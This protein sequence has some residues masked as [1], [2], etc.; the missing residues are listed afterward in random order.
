MVRGKSNEQ[1]QPVPTYS[2]TEHDDMTE[3]T[4]PAKDDNTK[5]LRKQVKDAAEAIIRYKA[6][7]QQ[8]NDKINALRGE[9]ADAG[10]PRSAFANALRL[11]E[12]E[13]KEKRTS[14]RV[15]YQLCM[16]AL[17]MG[18]QAELFAPEESDAAE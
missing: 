8:I 2:E 4:Q 12:M 6:Q 9:L 7:R 16:E 17:E 1:F 11:Y 14:Y 18:G 5:D 10:I 13:D 3:D 15:G